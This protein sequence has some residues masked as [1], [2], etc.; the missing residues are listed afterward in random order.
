MT[1]AQLAVPT[2]SNAVV[3]FQSTNFPPLQS[4]DVQQVVVRVANSQ[5]GTV[6][7][8]VSDNARTSSSPTWV[9]KVSSAAT[10]AA[11]PTEHVL[12]V[13][14]AKDI[15]VSWVNGGVDQVTWHP[16]VS[17]HCDRT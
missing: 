8:E 5:N 2:G 13:A 12:D 15:R 14:G 16:E 10:A 17:L 7:L 9:T 1:S 11:S 4:A 3:L 6:R